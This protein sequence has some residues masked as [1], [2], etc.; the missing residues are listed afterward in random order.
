MYDRC[1]S[2]DTAQLSISGI[3]HAA[4]YTIDCNRCDA[5]FDSLLTLLAFVL[6]LWLGGTPPVAACCVLHCVHA[7]G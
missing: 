7:G 1:A 2:V 6:L 4:T 3:G 5:S